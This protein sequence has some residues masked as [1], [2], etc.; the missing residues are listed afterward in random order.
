MEAEV[1]GGGSARRRLWTA[2]EKRRIVEQTLASDVSVAVVAR[3]HGVNA[4]QVFYWRKLYRAGQLG[5]EQAQGVRLLPVAVTDEEPSSS[6]PEHGLS[7]PQGVSINIEIPD[8][9][10]I[11]VEGAVDAA[12]VRAV[13]ESLCG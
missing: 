4:N 6:A 7:T 2:D 12:I 3:Q 10:L 5:D 11:S 8:R 13:L 9:A 1:V